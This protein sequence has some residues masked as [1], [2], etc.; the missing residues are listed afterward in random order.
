M[1]VNTSS[2]TR[3]RK[4]AQK[5]KDGLSTI[6]SDSPAPA[7]APQAKQ[8]IQLSSIIAGNKVGKVMPLGDGR[9]DDIGIAQAVCNASIGELSTRQ[10]LAHFSLLRADQPH[11]SFRDWATEKGLWQTWTTKG[12]KVKPVNVGERR[13]ALVQLHGDKAQATA[14]W[15]VLSQYDALRVMLARDKDTADRLAKAAQ[16][17]N[18]PKEV[19]TPAPTEQTKATLPD[20]SASTLSVS[21]QARQALAALSQELMRDDG[22]TWIADKLSAIISMLPTQ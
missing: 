15:R 8:T 21:C 11:N 20:V 14:E 3:A 1:N 5:I 7:P 17:A 2:V 12:G 6:A 19:A 16:A 18:A 10:L 13:L 9:L 22:Y 4:T